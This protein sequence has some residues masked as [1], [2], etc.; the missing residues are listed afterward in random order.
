M[1]LTR[2]CRNRRLSA[3]ATSYARQVV[4]TWRQSRAVGDG[5]RVPIQG[6]TL[7]IVAEYRENLIR[8][9]EGEPR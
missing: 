9:T 4:R 8:M 2:E 5:K 3:M 1:N 7:R 6:Q